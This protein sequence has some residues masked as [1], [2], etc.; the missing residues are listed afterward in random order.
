MRKEQAE[1]KVGP[2]PRLRVRRKK[3][4]NMIKGTRNMGMTTKRASKH[5][6]IS[7]SPT[8]PISLHRSK[9]N[10]LTIALHLIKVE[11]NGSAHPP[12]DASQCTNI[13]DRK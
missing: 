5:K 10:F 2:R 6:S 3:M 1:T 13:Y 11:S 4:E 9:M 8:H 7:L 12:K